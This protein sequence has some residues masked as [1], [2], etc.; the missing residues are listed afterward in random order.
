[1]IYTKTTENGIQKETP[2]T[3]L[4]MF[5]KCP[6]C[7][8]EVRLNPS[9]VEDVAADAGE[10]FSFDDIS[11]YCDDCDSYRRDRADVMEFIRQR[12]DKLSL[13]DLEMNVA[14]YVNTLVQNEQ[15]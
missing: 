5:C 1:M 14:A 15:A 4:Q 13:F 2:L 12:L 7:G 8:T 10:N 9:M 6:D 11:T 3:S